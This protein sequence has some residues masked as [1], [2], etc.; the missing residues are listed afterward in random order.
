MINGYSPCSRW[1]LLSLH[2]CFYLKDFGNGLLDNEVQS[3]SRHKTEVF[4]RSC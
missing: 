1:L 2:F 3:G 4:P